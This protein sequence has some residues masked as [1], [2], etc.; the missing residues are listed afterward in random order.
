MVAL[1]QTETG[2]GVRWLGY[3]ILSVLA[4]IAILS[5]IDLSR[6]ADPLIIPMEFKI[7]FNSVAKSAQKAEAVQPP[8]TPVQEII[9]PV[10]KILEPIPA[11]PPPAPVAPVAPV[12]EIVTKKVAPKA[13][14]LKKE[15]AP[16]LEPVQ[17]IEKIEQ[18]PLPVP[19]PR[20]KP[21]LTPLVKPE[22]KPQIAEKPKPVEP[23]KPVIEEQLVAALAPTPEPAKLTETLAPAPEKKPVQDA[24][25][26]I[27]GDDGKGL[28]T[29]VGKPSY[30]RR[31]QPR[32]PKRAQDMG[33]QGEVKLHVL[34]ARDGKPKEL[35]IA[36]SSGYRLLDKAALAAVKKWEFIPKRKGTVAVASWVAV[37]VN[38]VLR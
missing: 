38:F 37:P 13:I 4:N 10:E 34:V 2:Y 30:K 19:M 8:P 16:I 21:R 33:Q 35:K 9:K 14:A 17:E 28:S 25:D 23:I 1:A 24:S 5:V 31:G 11:P 3:L 7:S 18:P 12:A 32:Y 29:I 15:Q 36:K 27:Q 6:K 20:V 26:D 22:P